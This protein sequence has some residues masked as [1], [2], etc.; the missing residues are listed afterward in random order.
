VAGCCEWG[1]VP[2][3]SGATE[4]GTANA[5]FLP[6]VSSANVRPYFNFA[7]SDSVHMPLNIA[8]HDVMFLITASAKVVVLTFHFQ[9][10]NIHV[11]QVYTPNF[12]FGGGGGGTEPKRLRG[13]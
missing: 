5:R 10:L 13:G 7:S 11:M 12:M 6:A 1:D 4:F 9:H 8:S 3:G 2:S